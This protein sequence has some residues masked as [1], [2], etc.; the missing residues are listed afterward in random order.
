MFYLL[1][2]IISIVSIALAFKYDY[3]H[4]EMLIMSITLLT[5]FAVFNKMKR[6]KD[7]VFILLVIIY[8]FCSVH[9]VSLF[10]LVSNGFFKNIITHS[11]YAIL[12][13]WGNSLFFILFTIVL[14]FLTFSP[15]RNHTS[16]S[17]IH[18]H[19]VK[20]FSRMFLLC[21]IIVIILQILTLH[22][23]LAGNHE[24]ARL[25]LP[26]HLN[27]IID[28]YRASI[29]PIVFVIYLF[30]RFSAGAKI[31]TS[32]VIIYILYA[33][34]EIFVRNSKGSLIFSFLPVFLISI[35]MLK[36]VNK[37][38]II[39][40]VL[41]LVCAILFLYPVIE[42]A[43]RDGQITIQRVMTSAKNI[44]NV[45]D[46]DKSSLYIRTFLTGIYYIKCQD[47]ID[48]DKRSFD[49]TNV[50]ML[51]ILNGGSAFMTRVIDR[52]PESVHHSSGVTGLCDALLWGGYPMCYLIFI[53][54]III[55]F[56]ADKSIFLNRNPLYKVI[57]FVWFYQR[58]IGTTVSFFVDNLFLPTIVSIIMQVIIVNYYIKNYCKSLKYENR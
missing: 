50:P 32:Y 46:T 7:N 17:D 14:L 2:I 41:P 12:A 3:N 33:I 1:Y 42:N 40:Y 27:G 58:L 35:L 55:A 44:E 30:D 49:F 11:E 5:S 38:F 34:I 28:E 37:R 52:V 20:D 39:K 45:D 6:F 18:R 24:D 26:F 47:Y 13:E 4:F 48:N 29:Y 53:L 56:Y 21:S 36:Q 23:G 25:I 16:F 15:P 54:L 57:F 9:V 8:I 22:F 19:K 31:K 51:I 43:R 10:Q